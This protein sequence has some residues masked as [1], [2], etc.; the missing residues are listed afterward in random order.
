MSGKTTLALHSVA[1]AQ[2]KGG[3]AVFVDVEH[4]VRVVPF[5]KT[6]IHKDT[7]I[8]VSCVSLSFVEQTRSA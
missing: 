4:A 3:K 2:K 7:R 6:E 5:D 1:E 8:K